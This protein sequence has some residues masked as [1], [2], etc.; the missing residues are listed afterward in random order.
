MSLQCSQSCGGGSQ[1]RHRQC[2]LPD[3]QGGLSGC[4]GEESEARDC[5]TNPCPAFTAWSEW[6]ACTVSCG[7]G[8]RTS[9]RECVL[10]RALCQGD[11]RRVEECGTG[12]CEQW[13]SWAEWTPCTKSCGSGTRR[14]LRQC[15]LELTRSAELQQQ[16]ISL[17]ETIFYCSLS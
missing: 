9:Q 12:Q 8:E 2:L 6:S 13:T 7:G 16:Q 15:T 5:S 11:S 14:R 4:P 3:R 17:S 1:R 10:A